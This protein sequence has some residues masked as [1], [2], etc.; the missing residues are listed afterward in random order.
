MRVKQ[1]GLDECI[2]L[3][4]VGGSVF[5]VVDDGENI[6]VMP[7]ERIPIADIKK[8]PAYLIFDRGSENPAEEPAEEP[9]EE[10]VKP[11]RRSIVP[12]IDKTPFDFR[13]CESRKIVVRAVD[14]FCDRHNM[15]LRQ[16]CIGCGVP[17]PTY[18]Q[19]KNGLTVKMRDDGLE[20]IANF[21]NEVEHRI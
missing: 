21:M 14:E 13:G 5:V 3:A 12:P 15:S 16:F 19:Y 20:R 2:K 8:A 9:V 17:E 6:S 4:L 11:V 1:I 18:S 10:E 7:A